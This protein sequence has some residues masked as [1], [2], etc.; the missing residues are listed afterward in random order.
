MKDFKDKIIQYYSNVTSDKKELLEELPPIDESHYAFT[1]NAGVGDVVIINNLL[2]KDELNRSNIHI[3]S[4]SPRFF[5]IGKYNKFIKSNFFQT[6]VS[7]YRVEVLE[8]YN[9]GSGHIIQ[10]MRKFFQLPV[11]NKPKSF[12]NTDLNKVKNKIGIHLTVGPSANELGRFNKLPRQIYPHNIQ[13]IQEFIDNHPEYEFVELGGFSVGLENCRNFC[14]RSL[15]ESIEELS[16]C[17]YLI[18]LNSGFMNLAAC[19]DIKSIIILNIPVNASDIILPIL[20]D[21]R[22]PDMNWLYPQNVHLHQDNET[23]MVPLFN[24]TNLEKAINGEVYPFWED[25]HLDLIYD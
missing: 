25:K 3:N 13:V 2:F 1:F 17:E 4:Q 22:I 18:G 12:L 9:L 19:F 23:E 11:L 7:A 10:K 21:I 14:G 15:S 6:N 24:Y 16:T 5:E 8:D 20:K